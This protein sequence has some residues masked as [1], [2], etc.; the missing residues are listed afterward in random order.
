LRNICAARSTS[1]ARR[2]RGCD[3]P[4]ALSHPAPAIA[5]AALFR[6]PRLLRAA[7]VAG[8]ICYVGPD[9]DVFRFF[10]ARGVTV[11]AS[12][13]GWVWVPSLV[14]ALVVSIERHVLAGVRS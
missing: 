8:A 3:I 6:S 9:L 2:E 10:S 13:A 1:E 14:F 12:E 7:I 4:S 5:L 11:L